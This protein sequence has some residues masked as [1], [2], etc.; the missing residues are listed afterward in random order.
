[1]LLVLPLHFLENGIS[2]DSVTF[3][4]INHEE[5]DFTITMLI[6]IIVLLIIH[7]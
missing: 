7:T 2:L 6:L 1:M 5:K 4:G 3:L